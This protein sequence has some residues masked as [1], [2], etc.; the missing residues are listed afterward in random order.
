MPARGTSASGKIIPSA[1]PAANGK[2]KP[3]IRLPITAPVHGKRWRSLTF[4]FPE[5]LDSC[6]DGLE[7]CCGLLGA[8]P[9]ADERVLLGPVV[10]DP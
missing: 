4:V 2:L 5:V 8:A 3:P 1:K 9:S 10:G 6:A 7:S